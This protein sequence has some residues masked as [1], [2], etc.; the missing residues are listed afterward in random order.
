MQVGMPRGEVLCLQKPVQI[1]DI[2]YF[3]LF[4]EVS[5]TFP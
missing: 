2:P 5:I 4:P 3:V 1:S